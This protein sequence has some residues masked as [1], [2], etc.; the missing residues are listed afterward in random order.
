MAK[1]I[2][3][4]G[5]PGSGKDVI[6]EQLVRTGCQQRSFKTALYP[7][8]ASVFGLTVDAV[9]KACADRSGKDSPSSLF[10]GL[11]PRQ[12]LIHVSEDRVKP[13]LGDSYFGHCLAAT[14]HTGMYIVSDGGFAS[15]IKPILQ[16]GHK[17]CIVHLYREGCTFQNDSRRYI[18]DF[19]ELTTRYVNNGTLRDAGIGILRIATGIFN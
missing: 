13:V 12:A 19:P 14:I 17:V 18:Q 7:A 4:N 1:V 16:A 15:E 2:I 3:L 9:I 5:P 10:K 8:V 11:S 6:A